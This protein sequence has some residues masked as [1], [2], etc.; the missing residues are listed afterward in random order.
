M[1]ENMD[2]KRKKLYFESCQQM[3]FLQKIKQT[4]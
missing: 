4:K 3:F 2:E 1:D